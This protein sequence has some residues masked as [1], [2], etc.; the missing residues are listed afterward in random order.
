MKE[1]G[2]GVTPC[3][4]H[5]A[6]GGC[7]PARIRPSLGISCGGMG[8]SLP[9]SWPC[10][11]SASSSETSFS[12]D[13][14]IGPILRALRNCR[15]TGSSLDSSISRG[16][17]MTSSRRNSRPMLSGTVRAV[18]MSWVTMR[19]VAPISAFRSTIVWFR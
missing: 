13:I 5:Q 15:T 10:L 9:G 14:P 4:A 3:A 18:L 16:P 6:P 17:N 1:P 12:S 7:C 19:K 11:A 8:G 2:G